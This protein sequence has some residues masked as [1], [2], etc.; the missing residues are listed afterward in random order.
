MNATRVDECDENCACHQPLFAVVDSNSID[1]VQRATRQCAFALLPECASS[2]AISLVRELPALPAS[3]VAALAGCVARAPLDARAR[4]ALLG[5]VHARRRDRVGD[6][7]PGAYVTSFLV[8]AAATAAAYADDTEKHAARVHAG[9][10]ELHSSR[11]TDGSNATRHDAEGAI[12]D[13]CSVMRSVPSSVGGAA[14]VLDA[15]APTLLAQLP[16]EGIA[17]TELSG[18]WSARARMVMQTVDAL[19]PVPS[20]DAAST[21]VKDAEACG[22]V[23]SEACVTRERSSPKMIDENGAEIVLDELG[24]C[25][26]SF[27]DGSV[28]LHVDHSLVRAAAVDTKAVCVLGSAGWHQLV[29]A[30]TPALLVA[31]G[32][33]EEAAATTAA[34]WR[35]IHAELAHAATCHDD[36]A[37]LALG[38]LARRPE[39]VRALLERASQILQC[40][41]EGVAS[42]EERAPNSGASTASV[43]CA[44]RALSCIV[45]AE[46]AALAHHARAARA[47]AVVVQHASTCLAT[48]AFGVLAESLRT[49]ARIARL[50]GFE[51]D[52]VGALPPAPPRLAGPG[53]I[54]ASMSAPQ[55]QPLEVLPPLEQERDATL[56]V[57]ATDAE[58]LLDLEREQA[59][60]WHTDCVVDVVPLCENLRPSSPASS[61]VAQPLS[62]VAPVRQARDST[63]QEA[64][65]SLSTSSSARPAPQPAVRG[66][67]SDSDD[68]PLP[69]IVD[70]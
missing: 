29:R 48:S 5:A 46:N 23:W 14:R 57:P 59:H 32:A 69:G 24:T 52:D 17:P 13:V 3:L 31:L 1:P 26:V 11:T 38:L 25:G 28:A 60:T 30:L 63:Q 39:F 49:D 64:P 15:L 56:T 70:E 7:T 20:S 12:T 8:R 19:T 53:D 58:S 21:Q 40:A 6:G 22:R 16:T 10:A 51:G 68:E 33:S 2:L 37:S 35:G 44:L 65:V 50:P 43:R 18:G 54:F 42:G 62:E 55:M 47:L 27:G 36:H 9:A 4:V 67:D 34:E 45:R 61:T 41:A 66:D